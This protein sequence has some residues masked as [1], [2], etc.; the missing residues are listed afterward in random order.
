MNPTTTIHVGDALE[1][2]RSMPSDSIDAVVTDPPYSIGFMGK[3]WDT[4]T[5]AD[6]PSFGSWLAGFIDGEGC[7]TVKRHT[8]GSFG[9]T[10]A[11]KLRRD[12]RA[13]L[14]RIQRFVG[15]GTIINTTGSGNAKPLVRYTVQCKAGC[16]RVVDLLTRFP[17]RAKKLRDFIPWAEAVCE[18]NTAPRGNRWHGARDSIRLERLRE[19]VQ[20]AREYRDPPWSGNAFQ[21]WCR[22]WAE[23]CLRV[24]KPGGHMLVFGG[25]RT[26]HRLTCAIEDAGW[27]IRDCLMW[28]Y[29]EGFPK[30]L[31]VSKAIDKEAGAVRDVVAIRTDGCGNTEKSI[32]KTNGF[33]TSR[34]ATFDETAP[35]TAAAK[36][37]N[38]WGTALKPAWEPIILARKPLDGN[39]AQNVQKHGVGALN[40]D[41]C[42]V[43]TSGG[44]K[45]NPTG[46]G[47]KPNDVFGVYGACKTEPLG[48]G[49]WPANLIHDGSDEV[50][51]LFPDDAAR[52]FYCPKASGA[53]RGNETLRALPLFGITETR[54]TH[55][56]VK[57]TTLMAYLCRLVTPPGG[58][59]LDLFCGSGST[60]VAAAEEGF[61]FIG[62]E[63]NPQY[64]DLARKRIDAATG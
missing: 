58:L 44:T 64:A 32:H 50:V 7:F 3:Q 33:A 37:W 62:I 43:G 6:D 48:A 59:I 42:R 13:I 24:I 55:P 30:S 14:Q 22:E 26:Y 19:A 16:L 52:M 45:D 23:Q 63:L 17:L 10:M 11:I 39:V 8:R 18:W 5:N 15:Y 31:D 34:D 54:N 27:E 38:G 20:N 61:R 12:D 60:G 40:I 21:D 57:P 41:G 51:Q 56:T 29:A 47:N 25:T 9:C 46:D 53:D 4:H 49:R 28:V 1:V 2:L 36:T 35:A